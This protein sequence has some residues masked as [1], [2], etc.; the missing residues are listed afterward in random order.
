MEINDLKTRII[1]ETNRDDMGAG[2]ELETMLAGAI[3]RAVDHHADEL[4]WFN[5]G[6]AAAATGAGS[7]TVAYPAGMRLVLALSCAGQPLR[8][9]ALETIEAL[10]GSGRPALWAADGGAVRLWP[11]PD[12]VY[13]LAVSGV[14]ELGV[15][16]NISSS[17]NAWTEEGSDLVAARARMLLCRDS[18]RDVDGY[19]LAA[20]A[21]AEA[22]AKLRRETRRRTR[23]AR[24]CE[25]PGMA[26][27]LA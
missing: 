2:G 27:A 10:A 4:F 13:A 25:L 14:A 3:A 17:S 8:Q 7:A 20:E 16:D 12:A 21:E 26:T 24:S 9:A 15:P 23:F 5:R 6:S 19:R 1:T 11:V 18:L 22:L